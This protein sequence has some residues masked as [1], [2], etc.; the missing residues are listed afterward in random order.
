MGCLVD[1]GDIDVYNL[2]ISWLVVELVCSFSLIHVNLGIISFP[3]IIFI[4]KS[5]SLLGSYNL[6]KLGIKELMWGAVSYRRDHS[7]FHSS[8]CIPSKVR[9][10][11]RRN[12][13]PELCNKQVLVGVLESIL[14][15]FLFLNR[16]EYFY[17][18]QKHEEHL[19]FFF[20]FFLCAQTSRLGKCLRMCNFFYYLGSRSTM[21]H[22]NGFDRFSPRNFV[23]SSRNYTH[24]A[25]H[26]D[27]TPGRPK[28]D[29]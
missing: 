8:H 5:K 3:T 13:T 21:S 15:L 18:H 1:G 29:D 10:L 17:E 11:Q 9:A 28:A 20:F 26:P 7:Q 14:F 16:F 19:H 24:D 6:L 22:Y 23:H 25:R 27:E 12:L 2:R 4:S